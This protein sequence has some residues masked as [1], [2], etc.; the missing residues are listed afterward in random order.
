MVQDL[1][2]EG[3]S[4]ILDVPKVTYT[5]SW[6]DR[7]TDWVRQ[8]PK[9][10]WLYYAF[11]ATLLLVLQTAVAWIEGVI[12]FGSFLPV[13]I[14]MSIVY[15]LFPG[16]IHY[17]DDRAKSS[18]ASL[19]PLLM[20]NENGYLQIQHRLTT[21]PSA[22]T[23]LAGLFAIAFALLVET[24]G[25]G[26]YRL[27]VLDSYP[28]SAGVLRVIYLLSWALFGTFIYHMAHQLQGVN[29]VYSHYT[30]I[31]L[32]RMKPLYGLSR[33]TAITAAGFTLIPYT[34]LLINPDININDPIIFVIYLM[35]LLVAIVVFLL[36][37]LGIHKLQAEKKA[38]LL[39]EA[40]QRYESMLLKMH[41]RI[42]ED[43][44][45]GFDEIHFAISTLEMEIAMLKRIPTWPWQPETVRWLITA[46]VIPLGVWLMQYALQLWI[47]A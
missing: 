6:V 12:P 34:W 28:I 17:F 22:R 2:S 29:R 9:A 42:D 8:R 41:K 27:E 33:L 46:L 21:L 43:D 25:S 3:N 44:I 26:P 32:F 30:R 13:P 24:I 14:F 37:Q 40:R 39:G 19:R 18:L 10:N 4:L 23:L 47:G 11:L 45:Q 31:N 15:A 1:R 7:L 36:P 5:P 38:K 16:L 35:V 20:I